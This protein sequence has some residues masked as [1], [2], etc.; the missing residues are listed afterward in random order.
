MD[1]LLGGELNTH[2]VNRMIAAPPPTEKKK[3]APR[4]VLARKDTEDGPLEIILP[5]DSLWY[6]AYVCN[7]LMVEPESSMAKKFRE[8]FRLPYTNFLQ[9]VAS[10]SE[11][12][13]FDRW[14]GYKSNNKQAS[15]I[16]L[17]VLGSLR[18]LGRGWTF[19]DVEENTAISKEVHRTFFHCFVEFGSTVLYEK[20]VLTP[21]NVNEAKTHMREFDEA[22]FPG[23]VGSSDATHITTDRCEYNLKNNHLGPKSSLTARSYNICVNHR[24]RIL[25]STPGGPARWNDQTM[26]RFD[27]FI[28]QIRSDGLNLQD[29]TFELLARGKGGEVIAVTYKGVYVIVDNGYLTWSCTVPP[30][31]VTSNMDEIR[32]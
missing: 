15:P 7:F 16:E 28:T 23:C 1:S 22:G 17:L 24:R 10:V 11:S 6:K 26:V 20:Y 32:W 29:N 18:Y 2:R 25:H 9:L 21:D 5:E 30:F 13:L 31:T 19:D 14:C 8:R 12:D 3:R 4:G 27:R